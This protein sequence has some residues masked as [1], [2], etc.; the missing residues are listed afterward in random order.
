MS[1]YA[2]YALAAFVVVGLLAV[3]QQAI[4]QTSVSQVATI[5]GEQ[6]TWL[7]IGQVKIEDIV[8]CENGTEA[9]AMGIGPGAFD[10][11]LLFK[12]TGVN[13]DSPSVDQ[14]SFVGFADPGLGGS[15]PAGM[16]P[17]GYPGVDVGVQ[18]EKA[19]FTNFFLDTVAQVDLTTGE[20]D[21]PTDYTAETAED[22]RNIS[23][24]VDAQYSFSN[25][26]VYVTSADGA[27][28]TLDANSGEIMSQMELDGTGP[29]SLTAFG[30]AYAVA[31]QN[32]GGLA[33]ADFT[34]TANQITNVTGLGGSPFMAV[35]NNEGDRVYVSNQNSDSVSVVSGS[36]CNKSVTA[37]IDVGSGPRHIALSPNGELLFVSNSVDNSVSVIDTQS[38][39]VQRTIQVAGEEEP[40]PLGVL[41][42]SNSGRYLYAFWEG[43][44]TGSPGQFEVRVF[45]VSNLY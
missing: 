40:A 22:K 37:E 24:P 36:G 4:T 1:R 33:C 18:C 27:L 28:Y 41:Q 45:D 10:D 9:W 3:P 43:G 8:M 20:L 34:A 12:I 19:V 26:R 31:L 30:D 14:D 29:G 39:T 23:A 2:R 17:R 44:V 32:V 35:A 15:F 7:G 21:W 25:Q 42:V 13:T 38:L 11:A 16:G 6:F 5:A